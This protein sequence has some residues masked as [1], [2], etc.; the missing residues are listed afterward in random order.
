MGTTKHRKTRRNTSRPAAID[1]LTN[2][3]LSKAANTKESLPLSSFQYANNA[4]N[5]ILDGP[6]YHEHPLDHDDGGPF[7]IAG[8]FKI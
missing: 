5:D 6:K 1:F 4:N 8:K 2:I 3:S 7:D